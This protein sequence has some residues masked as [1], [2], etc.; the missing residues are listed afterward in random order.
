MWCSLK[1]NVGIENHA[2]KRLLEL[3]PEYAEDVVIMSNAYANAGMSE[4]KGEEEQEE[5]NSSRL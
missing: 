4:E 1:G 3:E 5:K 2:G